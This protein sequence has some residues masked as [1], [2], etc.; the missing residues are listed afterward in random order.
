MLGVSVL[1]EILQWNNFLLWVFVRCI[2]FLFWPSNRQMSWRCFC[3]CL[4]YC[5]LCWTLA[6]PCAIAYWFICFVFWFLALCVQLRRCLIFC[7]DFEQCLSEILG[8]IPH[9]CTFYLLHVFLGVTCCFFAILQLTFCFLVCSGLFACIYLATAISFVDVCEGF[10]DFVARIGDCF[11]WCKNRC[12]APIYI[13]SFCFFLTFFSIMHACAFDT[14]MYKPFAALNRPKLYW[15]PSLFV[16]LTSPK[17]GLFFC[18]DRVLPNIVLRAH[19]C[20][21]LCYFAFSRSHKSHCTHPHPSLHMRT[22][23]WP[24]LATA[25][26]HHVRGNFPGHRSQ[27]LACETVNAPS[28]PCFCVPRAPY[29]PTHP[30]AP[31]RIHLHALMT[32]HTPNANIYM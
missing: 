6:V 1:N 26:K 14:F 18:H 9:F 16:F 21:F 22:H 25:T 31:I 2:L 4:N 12:V 20:I 3:A 30:S 28:L 17:L 13:C 11:F 29:V 15:L 23:S 24:F 5:I 7:S 8:P 10:V 27:I 19:L 32:I